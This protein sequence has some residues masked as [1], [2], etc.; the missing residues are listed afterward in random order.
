M[1]KTKSNVDPK[2]IPFK[3]DA[4]NYGFIK[5]IPLWGDQNELSE[6]RIDFH[7]TA[8]SNFEMAKQGFNSIVEGR[9]SPCIQQ[10]KSS[11]DQWLECALCGRTKIMR[12]P[13]LQGNAI[14]FIIDACD[15]LKKEISQHQIDS[16]D[17][18]RSKALFK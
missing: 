3:M 12:F 1:K 17:I 6:L 7:A 16:A 14:V 5:V 15:E 4:E 11:D 13:M 2:E 10:P 18:R 9:K 8:G